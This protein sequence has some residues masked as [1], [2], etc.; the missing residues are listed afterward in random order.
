MINA[1]VKTYY[2]ST[3]S[4]SELNSLIA[5]WWVASAIIPKILKHLSV[6]Q[7]WYKP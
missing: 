3:K 4:G 2:V 1:E 6:E 7:E 5:C